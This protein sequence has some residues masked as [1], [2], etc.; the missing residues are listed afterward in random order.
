LSLFDPHSPGHDGALIVSKGVFTKFATRLPVS[1]SAALP[2]E[3]G[4]RHHAAMGLSEKTDAL[5]L[6]ASEERGKISIFHMGQ[7]FPAENMA[8]IVKIIE[9]HWKNILSYPFAVYQRETRRTFVY[10]AAI[11]FALAVIFWSTII[12]AQSERVEKVISVPVEYSLAAS[13]LVLVGEREKELQLYLAGV[14]STLDALKPSDLRVKIDLSAY[15][16]GTQSVFITNDNIRLPKGVSLLETRPSR[17]E[18]TLAAITEKWAE[19]TPQLVG[20]LPPGVALAEVTV[21]PERVKILSP[22]FAEALVPVSVTTT[23]VYLESIYKNS[24]I[25]CKII[26]PQTVQPAASQWPDVEVGILVEVRE[27]N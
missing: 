27:E 22:D 16:P 6:V 12:V 4:T 20:S 21:T 5:V 17:L 8:Q 25:L 23:P 2:E 11:S 15:G 18:L 3:Y 14:K 10:Q 9:A 24:R 1:E 26:A 19:I 13:D 7:M